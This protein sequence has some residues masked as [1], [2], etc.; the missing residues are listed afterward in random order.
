M[1]C[2]SGQDFPSFAPSWIHPENLFAKQLSSA[3]LHV[4][5]GIVIWIV[6]FYCRIQGVSKQV[7]IFLDISV[8]INATV[9]CLRW[10]ERDMG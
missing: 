3:K 8:C 10:A 4:Y 9:L 2:N 5:P 1:K 6:L 7:L